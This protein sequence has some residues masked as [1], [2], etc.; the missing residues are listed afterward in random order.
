MGTSSDLLLLFYVSA[1]F[2]ILVSLFGKSSKVE[3]N[4]EYASSSLLEISSWSIFFV[5]LI[6]G[7]YLIVMGDILT[8][9]DLALYFAVITTIFYVLP[10]K[11]KR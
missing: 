4:T 3:N 6:L 8:K 7:T 1:Y 11:I 10:K 5:G 9:N 2:F